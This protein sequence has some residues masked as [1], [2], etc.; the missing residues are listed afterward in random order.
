M[1]KIL[2]MFTPCIANGSY[3]RST[4]PT[5]LFLRNSFDFESWVYGYSFF[6]G[7]PLIAC[8]NEDT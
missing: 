4:F 8:L 7:K 2:A 1:G 5:S 6:K 3:K